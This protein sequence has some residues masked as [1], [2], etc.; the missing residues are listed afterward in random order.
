MLLGAMASIIL[1]EDKQN[2]TTIPSMILIQVFLYLIIWDEE[3]ISKMF[4]IRVW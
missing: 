2:S 3:N 1:S 4:K